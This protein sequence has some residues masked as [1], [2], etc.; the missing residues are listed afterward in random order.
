MHNETPLALR[1]R[2]GSEWMRAIAGHALVREAQRR[3]EAAW[4]EVAV[5]LAGG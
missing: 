4:R 5:F 3:R 1:H 2:S